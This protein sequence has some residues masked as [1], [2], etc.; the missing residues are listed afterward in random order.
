M[1]WEE[2]LIFREWQYRKHVTQLRDLGVD[3][4][5]VKG[6][7]YALSSPMTLLA[8]DKVIIFERT[9]N[10]FPLYVYPIVGSTNDLLKGSIAGLSNGTTIVAECQT[11]GKG[12][13]GRHWISPFGASLAV[14]TYWGLV[15][16]INQFR[17]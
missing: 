6:K 17:A 3:I 2:S 13:Q 15:P 14:S 10:E 1:S 12:R 4:F 11:K 7:G 9:L 5:S 8:R 16:V